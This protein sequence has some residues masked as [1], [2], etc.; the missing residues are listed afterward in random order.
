M[1]LDIKKHLS[2]IAAP[3]VKGRCKY[4]LADLLLAALCTVICNGEDCQ[5]MELFCETIGRQLPELFDFGKE[6]PS[7]DTFNRL[8]Q[9][10]DK[11]HFRSVIKVYGEEVLPYLTDKQICLD[12]KKLRGASPKTT[13][14]QGVYL[15]NAWVSENNICMGQ[16]R[17]EDKSNE[18]TAIP[19]LLDSLDI[20]DAVVSIDAMGCQKNIA[21]KIRAKKGDYLL[22]LK[23]KQRELFEEVEI[24]FKFERADSYN[25]T[26]DYGHGRYEKRKCSVISSSELLDPA[27]LKGWKDL[28]TIVMVEAQ[29][30]ENDKI[31][32]EK[33]YYIS[34][35]GLSGAKYFNEL[36]RGHW[37]IENKM[38]WHLDVTFGEDKN[39][40]RKG[41]AP[42][43]LATIRVLALQIVSRKKSKL[44]I[45]KRRYKASLDA[46]YLCQLLF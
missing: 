27:V 36:V 2:E 39:R 33:R 7:H 23:S 37:A 25:E 4:K 46:T 30:T 31:T 38:H 24:A 5:D 16:V 35:D 11:D 3:R 26:W 45:A 6:L 17:V 28:R 29:R 32:T 8:L 19:E 22:S 15:L 10:V 18:I 20:E 21:K 34:S 41:N 12:G 14:N 40:I 44:S 9:K 13:G 1:A 43:N 42:E